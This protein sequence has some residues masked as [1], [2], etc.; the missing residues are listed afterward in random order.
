MFPEFFEKLQ[1]QTRARSDSLGSLL[2]WCDSPNTYYLLCSSKL[3]LMH[4]AFA[5]EQPAL[6]AAFKIPV[7]LSRSFEAKK[8]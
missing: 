7:K 3:G 1:A 8:K 5:L 2:V 4:I 6:S